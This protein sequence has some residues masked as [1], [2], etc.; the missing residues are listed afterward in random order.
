MTA[1][2]KHEL[3]TP[4]LDGSKI[5]TFRKGQRWRLGLNVQF[6]INN[7]TPQRAEFRDPTPLVSWQPTELTTEGFRIDNRLL[8]PLELTLL[9]KQD[10]FAT[11]E[12]LL[13]FFRQTR[14]TLEGTAAALD[15]LSVPNAGCRR[16][17]GV[18][19]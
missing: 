3:V 18:R 19:R 9:A 17:A 5:H 1:A 7:R 2:F 16:D 14:V 13:G 11:S 15:S 4:I 8:D 6:V 10:G 12:Q